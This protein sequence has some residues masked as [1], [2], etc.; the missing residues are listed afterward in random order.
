VLNVLAATAK[1]SAAEAVSDTEPK[2]A[3][4]AETTSEILA[5]VS[6]NPPHGASPQEPEPQPEVPM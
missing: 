6:F 4:A 1:A 2:N 5:A 3:G